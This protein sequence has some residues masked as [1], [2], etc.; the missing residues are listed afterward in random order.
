MMSIERVDELGC[1]AGSG[2]GFTH[3]AFKDVTYAKVL[4]NILHLYFPILVRKA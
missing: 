4:P 2:A 1:D 3:T